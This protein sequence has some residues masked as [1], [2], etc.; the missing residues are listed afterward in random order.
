M[1][2]P[3][4]WV[5]GADM[6]DFKFGKEL[7]LLTTEDY[8][9]VFGQVDAKVQ[10][11]NLLLLARCNHRD[12]HRLGL[13]VA[14]KHVRRAVH[15]NRIKRITRE[16]FRS[17]PPSQPCLDVIVLARPG[18]DRMDNRR[19]SSILRQQWQTLTNKSCAH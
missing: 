5:L 15:R 11:R 9:G 18:L 4:C 14:K 1:T 7:R 8:Q 12:T 6:K 13:I 17:R 3:W 2:I 16:M 10:H 19:L